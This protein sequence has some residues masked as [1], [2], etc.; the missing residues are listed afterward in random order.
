[1]PAN[2]S[3]LLE[4]ILA[5]RF[6]RLPK[7]VTPQSCALV[8]FGKRAE[9]MVLLSFFGSAQVNFKMLQRKTFASFPFEE[10]GQHTFVF[11]APLR[12]CIRTG[13]RIMIPRM[14]R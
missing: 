8:P 7:W 4:P 6:A 3:S 12:P 2:R 13:Y 11:V 10:S 1:M 9:G 14:E 5:G